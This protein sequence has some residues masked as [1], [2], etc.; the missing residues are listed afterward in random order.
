MI[1]SKDGINL[2][3]RFEGCKLK[4][5]RCPAGVL[6]IG[7]GCTEGVTE[8]MTISQDMADYLLGKELAEF[9]MGIAGLVTHKLT[10]PQFD[11]LVCFTYNVGLGAFKKSTLL[12]RINAGE[13]LPA[14]EEFLKWD[15][16]AGKVLPGLT[17]RRK[18]EREL[19]LRGYTK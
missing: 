15:K 16:A 11:A 17:A 19:F 6:T 8:G 13:M 5:Y 4:A 9:E 3:K 10:Q 7:F 2:I 12:K 18:A 14:A 1:T